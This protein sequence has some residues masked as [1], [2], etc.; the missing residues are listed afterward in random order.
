[1]N[2]KNRRVN[3]KGILIRSS[4]NVHF[5]LMAM[6]VLTL[7]MIFSIQAKAQATDELEDFA[8]TVDVQEDASMKMTYHLTW[9]VLDDS[10]GALE[11]IDLGVPNSHHED[12]TPL[13]ETIDHI[14]DNGNKLAIY[15][16]RSYGE[17]ETVSLD[18]SM[19]QDH[20][21]QIDKWTEGETVYTFT[22]AWF[23]TMEIK[24]L[25]IR[26]NAAQASAWQPDCL[27]EEG[28]LV[29]RTSLAAGD[30][31]TL[32]VTYPNDAFGFDVS[33]Q[34]GEGD[35][36]SR[37]MDSGSSEDE[38]LGI[39]ELIGGMFVGLIGLFVIVAPFIF[40][41]KMFMWI[42]DGIGFGPRQETK[43][44]IT[45]TKI[46]YFDNCPSCGAAREEGKDSCQYC[47]RSMIKSE[48]VL[49]EEEIEEPEK[50]NKKGTYRYGDSGHT[51]IRVNVVNIPVSRS[52]SFWSSRSG[53]SSSR[54]GGSS[55][56]SSCACACASSC[57]CACACASSGRA[58]CSVK[59]FYKKN[60]HQNRIRVESKRLA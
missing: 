15:L 57:A 27:Q 46:D 51:Y 44:K 13:S 3:T 43:K 45:R 58:G 53:S 39:F 10:I 2:E 18:F 5:L 56:H 34:Q 33:R 41:Y 26:W 22:P 1:M 36:G 60:V 24:Q 21:Y 30:K 52:R 54:S 47:G 32:S 25:T 6:A 28:Y 23:D 35:D 59:D 17:G 50:Y 40:I 20:M 42:M 37:S 48:V 16:D 55:H 4:R 31:Y 8:I 14:E 7:L 12:I 19:N 29:F 11:W 9:K 49:K 38:E